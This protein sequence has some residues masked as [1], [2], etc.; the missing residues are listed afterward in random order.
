MVVHLSGYM[1]I[2]IYIMYGYVCAYVCVCI[3]TYMYVVMCVC[4]FISVHA[5]VI[6][7]LFVGCYLVI[8]F[9]KPSSSLQSK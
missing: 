1:F 4:V 6:P 3:Y 2:C 5:Y 8:T 7:Y 9:L